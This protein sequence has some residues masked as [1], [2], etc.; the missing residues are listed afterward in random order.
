M[1]KLYFIRHGE[2]DWN[3]GHLLQG[4]RDIPLNDHGREEARRAARALAAI[5]LDLCVTSPLSRTRETASL[6]LAGRSIP[7]QT[8]PDL[9]EVGF[10]PYEGLNIDQ[11]MEQ[12][13]HP[14]YAYFTD[15]GNYAAKGGAESLVSLFERCRHFLTCWQPTNRAACPPDRPCHVVPGAEQI[16]VVAHGALIR[17]MI[18]VVLGRTPAE[19]WEGKVQQNCA[20]TIIAWENG[21]WVLEQEDVSLEETANKK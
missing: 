2:T 7:Q 17:G 6:L 18:S 19:I 15:P 10:G 1:R 21:R 16:L 3:V 14:L 12:P 4:Q 9:L 8:D 13:G 5:P 11:I 20:L